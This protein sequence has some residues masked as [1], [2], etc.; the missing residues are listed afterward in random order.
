M[1]IECKLHRKGG[2][3]VTIEGVEYHFAPQADGRHVATVDNSKHAQRFLDIPEAYSAI[4]AEKPA[5][6]PETATQTAALDL[7]DEPKG[8]EAQTTTTRRRGRTRRGE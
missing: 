7:G 5:Q 2:T 8:D 4:K 3:R 6:K 1:K